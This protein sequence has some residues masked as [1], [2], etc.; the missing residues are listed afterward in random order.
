VA[1]ILQHESDHDAS[2]SSSSSYSLL[3]RDPAGNT[4]LHW[5]LTN[6]AAGAVLALLA[7][8]AA[9]AQLARYGDQWLG[10]ERLATATRQSALYPGFSDAMRADLAREA[11]LTYVIGPM[12]IRSEGGKRT[13]YV[14]FNAAPG[15]SETDIVTSAD[16]RLRAA[17]ASGDVSL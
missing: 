10:T 13:Q 4:P 3:A 5:A 14:M 7:S 2:S 17:I 11:G 6:K 9:Q 8:P 16:A 15:A 1:D 12:A